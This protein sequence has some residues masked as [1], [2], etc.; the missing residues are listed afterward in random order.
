MSSF[1]SLKLNSL[2]KH[3]FNPD[4]I[5]DENLKR[6]EFSPTCYLLLL[7]WANDVQ[8]TIKFKH[9][10]MFYNIKIFNNTSLSDWNYEFVYETHN[11]IFTI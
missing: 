2:L 6:I 3:L 11:K 5:F 1:D 4:V 8:S 7:E 10:T 9:L